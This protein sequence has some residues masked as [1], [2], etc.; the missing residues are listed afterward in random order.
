MSEK[1]VFADAEDDGEI[2][3]DLEAI[4]L[5][6][7]KFLEVKAEQEVLEGQRRKIQTELVTTIKGAGLDEVPEVEVDGDRKVK[8]VVVSP[9]RAVVHGPKLKRKIGAKK[10]AKILK[11]PEIDRAKLEA[12][13][14]LGE[15]DIND[16]AECTIIEPTTPYIKT[17]PVK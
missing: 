3:L 14:Q 5:Q 12:A 13:V 16:V 9:E 4:G 1:D 11:D 17:S 8:V 15:I 2:E 10:Y 6:T 7:R